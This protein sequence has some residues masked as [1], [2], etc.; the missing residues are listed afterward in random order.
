VLLIDVLPFLST[1]DEPDAVVRG[2]RKTNEFKKTGGNM[3]RTSIE[4]QTSASVLVLFICL[5]TCL[6]AVVTMPAHAAYPD[7]RIR[8]VV[9]FAPGGGVDIIARLLADFMSKDLGQPIIVENKPGAGTIVG[10]EEVARATPD[11]YTLLMGSPPYTINPSIYAHLPFDTSKAFAPVALIAR[12]FDIVVINPKLPFKSIQD[13]IAYAKDNPNKLNFGSS[14]IGTSLHL[15]G[16]LFKT[17]AHVEMTHVPYKGTAPATNDLLSGQVQIMFSTIPSVVSFVQGGQLRALAI[18]S[19]H[20]SPAFPGVPTVAEAGLPDYV[21]EGWYGLI[22][23]AGT[24]PD[25]LNR[26]N[27]SVEKAISSGVF[28]TIEANEGLTFT[29]GSPEDFTRYLQSEDVRWR[30]VVKNAHIQLQ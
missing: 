21:V 11:G 14:G 13:V 6:S 27:A 10:T 25:V 18:T 3:M 26:L 23:P 19:D 16:E 24:P 7:K 12:Y 30:D 17:M 8:L 15:A 22:A 4:R 9:P 29:A 2:E 1:T 5:L 28:K 20:P